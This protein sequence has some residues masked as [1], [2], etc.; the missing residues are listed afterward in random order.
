MPTYGRL[1]K[2]TKNLSQELR[3]AIDRYAA[4]GVGVGGGGGG[5]GG[6]RAGGGGEGLGAVGRGGEA[7]VIAHPQRTN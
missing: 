4:R 6:W 1:K 3:A 2:D 5:A 7:R